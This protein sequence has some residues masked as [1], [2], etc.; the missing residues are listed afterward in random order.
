M[1]PIETQKITGK[2]NQ[3]YTGSRK[4]TDEFEK[5]GFGGNFVFAD[6]PVSERKL[7]V[8]LVRKKT[9]QKTVKN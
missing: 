2:L 1:N 3:K 4:K 5:I 7:E 8:S 9:R 6:K